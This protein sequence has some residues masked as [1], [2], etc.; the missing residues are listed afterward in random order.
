M[1]RDFE[2]LRQILLCL[3]A[4]RTVR[5][6]SG[7]SRDLVNEHVRILAEAGLVDVS[8]ESTR[9][10][11]LLIAVRLTSFGH[12]FL[13]LARNAAIWSQVLGK[14]KQHQIGLSLAALQQALSKASLAAAGL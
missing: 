11:P 2:L 9:M 8:D 13:D 1:K 12:D 5:E 3:E 4:D 7:S 10:R 14:L 6:I